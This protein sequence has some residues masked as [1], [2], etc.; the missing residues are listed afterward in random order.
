MGEGEGEGEG[1]G[2]A[3]ERASHPSCTMSQPQWM[4]V[5]DLKGE[6]CAKKPN[7]ESSPLTQYGG[8]NLGEGEGEGEGERG[9]EGHEVGGGWGR[10]R[11]RG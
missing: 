6:M 9:E 1:E 3:C 4:G 10:G 11:G 2:S 8:S 5:S 7:A